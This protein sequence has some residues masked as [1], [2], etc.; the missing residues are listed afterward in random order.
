MLIFDKNHNLLAKKNNACGAN[1]A[2]NIPLQSGELYSFIVYSFGETDALPD[3]GA[4]VGDSM[5]SILI[6]LNN[7]KDLMVYSKI[8][9]ELRAGEND[10]SF[11]L[12]HTFS[13]IE[14]KIIT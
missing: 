3:L 10:L 9:K 1:T 11:V 5:D 7:Y 13:M 12:Q 4:E 8:D 14:T 6:A 2:L